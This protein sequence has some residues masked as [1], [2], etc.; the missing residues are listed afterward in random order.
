[1]G[2]IIP[3]LSG[4]E[5]NHNAAEYGEDP[6]F[7]NRSIDRESPKRQGRFGSRGSR[8]KS[9]MSPNA[10]TLSTRLPTAQAGGIT[11]GE[12]HPDLMNYSHGMDTRME[13]LS[14]DSLPTTAQNS[15]PSIP[16]RPD[17]NQARSPPR[18][19]SRPTTN[20]GSAVSSFPDA[21]PSTPLVNE[22]G[23]SSG[24]ERRRSVI[25]VPSPKKGSQ[26]SP[27]DTKDVV[28]ES[29]VS[30]ERHHRI[31][32]LAPLLTER[33]QAARLELQS[34]QAEAEKMLRQLEATEAKRAKIE[35]ERATAERE[36]E[37]I[38]K[39]LNAAKKKKQELEAML[40]DIRKENDKLEEGIDNA[41]GFI[42][43][44]K[45]SAVPSRPG[46]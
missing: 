41:M 44:N 12:A 3:E 33:S 14:R 8:K 45:P 26:L 39:K 2:N 38:L 19:T 17:T 34:V 18:K 10:A 9:S 23:I 32:T 30:H 11:G 13:G 46:H 4:A 29:P 35:E 42:K 25:G 24:G 36:S 22:S 28:S 31:P 40:A 20:S 6:V 15:T 43:A 7:N 1:L 37:L 5:V 27:A 16:S 21:G